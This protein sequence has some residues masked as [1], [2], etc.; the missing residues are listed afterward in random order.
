MPHTLDGRRGAVRA[1][2]AQSRASTPQES[3]ATARV[4]VSREL[5]RALYLAGCT[6]RELGEAVGAPPQHV[7]EWCDPHG[8][9]HLSV[10]D[11]DLAPREVAMHLVRYLAD[12]L[13]ADVSDRLEGEDLSDRLHALHRIIGATSAVPALFSR[14]LADGAIDREERELLIEAIDTASAVLQGLRSHL[15]RPVREVR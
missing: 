3:R 2:G 15:M 8:R 5:I 6:Q 11:L 10:A 14:A 4:D 13:H 1:T 12:H 7:Q 9:R